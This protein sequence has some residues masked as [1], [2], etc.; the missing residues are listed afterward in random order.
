M[1]DLK[2]IESWIK[3]HNIDEIECLVPDLNGIFRGKIIPARKFLADLPFGL[4]LPISIF[5]QMVNGECAEFD[6]DDVMNYNDN[7]IILIPDEKTLQIVP[8][9]SNKTA[10]IICDVV[11]AKHDIIDFA[12]RS[13]LKKILADYDKMGLSPIV[14]PEVEFYLVQK[15]IDPD[16]P[17][18]V[19]DGTS[20]R[21]EFGAQAYGIDQLYEYDPIID[22]I[23]EYCEIMK[24]GVDTITHEAG[25]VQLEFNFNH[26]NALHL[27]DQVSYF[28]RLVRRAALEHG[29][30]AT[31]MAKPHQDKPGSAMHIHQSIVHNNDKS[32]IFST[33]S[34]RDSKNLLNYIG[35]LKKYIPQAFP[36]FAPNVNSYRRIAPYFDAPINLHWG[37]DNRTVGLRVPLS[38]PASRRVENRVI[39]ADTNPYLAFAGTLACGLLGMQQK[40]SPG[41]EVE[42]NAYKLA[43]NLPRS[44]QDSIYKMSHSREM[45]KILGAKFVDL[46]CAVKLYEFDMYHQV[47]SSWERK[48]LLTNV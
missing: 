34:G 4:K 16:Y 11:D 17:L 42:G 23:Y 8:W 38:S 27:A 25:P 21:S 19:P 18:E 7:D 6:L 36:L 2:Y 41:R 39:G 43:N 12:P 22:K 44:L 47:I 15:N 26:G 40:I 24:I 5:S 45:K 32:N 33:K 48:Y 37:V 9:F 29:V 3:A 14:A 35:G 10:Q 28:K 30:Y 13:V 46:Y 1:S 20:G 31:F